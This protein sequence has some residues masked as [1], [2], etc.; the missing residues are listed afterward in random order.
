MCS[1][2]RNKMTNSNNFSARSLAL[3]SLVALERDGRYSN[4]EIDSRIRRANLSDADRGLYTR[5]VYGVT[6]RRITLDYI[7]SR[8]SETP[9][10]ALDED[11]KTALRL[12]IYQLSFMDRI[13]EHAAVSETVDLVRKARRGFVNAVLRSYIRAGKPICLPDRDDDRI[14]YLSVKYSVP[15]GL[16]EHFSRSYGEDEAESLLR[17]MAQEPK[18]SLRINTLKIS[19]ENALLKTGGTMSC[20]ADGIILVDGLDERVRDG[21]DAGEW[22]VQDEA[23]RA[24][25]VLLGAKAGETVVDTC[26][27]PGGKSFS[28]AIDME[29]TGRIYSFDL[30]R[31]K[32]SLIEKGAEKLGISIIETSERDARKPDES[33]L[34][35]ADRV[36]CDAPCSGL[37]VIAKK[38][39][40]RYKNLD[41]IKKLPEIQYAVLCGAAEYVRDG[42]VLVY[43]TCTLNPDENENTV[44]KFL[45]EHGDFSLDSMKT[46]FPHRDGCDGF[47]AARMIKH[48]GNKND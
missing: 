11:V 7:I 28:A 6:E 45:S 42:G 24:A 4:I 41:E 10:D 48:T 16:A 32:L 27:C 13:P 20:I 18:V 21:I 35:R 2:I 43:S 37:G 1:L 36:L 47:F 23:S 9:I 46:F 40:I 17:A 14:K 30:H 31:N 26:A 44:T 38:P 39:D 29:N 34:G 25:T 15:T 22:F 12:G 33:L 3:E 8:F 5:L 19:A